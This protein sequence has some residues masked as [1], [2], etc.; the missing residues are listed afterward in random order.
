MTKFV[1]AACL[2]AWAVAAPAE[3]EQTTK[4]IEYLVEFIRASDVVFIHNGTEH[5]AEEAAAHIRRKREHFKRKIRSAEDFIALT[6]TKSLLG[7]EPY[8]IRGKDGREVASAAWLTE[9]L[10]RFR[11]HSRDAKEHR[12]QSIPQPSV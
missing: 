4:E 5:T 3:G 8:R 12:S 7:K 6:A 2:L 11:E 10:Q 9:E 1:L